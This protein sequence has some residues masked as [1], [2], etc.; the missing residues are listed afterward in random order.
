M[1]NNKNSGWGMLEAIRTHLNIPVLGKV[2]LV[3][4]AATD[5]NYQKATEILGTDLSG[6][7]RVF[8]GSDA[9]ASAYDQM[10]T[11]ANDVVLLEGQTAHTLT[12]MLT[13]SKSRC[14]FFGL[15]GGGRLAT[16]G[17]RVYMGVT[18]VATDLAPILNT[19]TRNTFRN[20]KVENASTTNES[21]YGFI[22]NGEGTLIEN[23]HFLKTAGLN[24]ANHAHFWLAGDS[25]TI[26]NVVVGQSN[27]PNT[28][29]GFGILIDGK[30]G[31]ASS[32]VKENFL[33][34]IYINMSVGGAVQATSCFIKIADTAAMNF[35]NVIKD[36]TCMNF[37]PVSGTIMTDA[38][39]APAS[40]VS[41][42]LFLRNPAFFG[43]TGVIDTASAG[44][45]IAA[46]GVAPV[47][48]GGLATNL[49]D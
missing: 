42:S 10:T 22:E 36:L 2:F 23:C 19:G 41:G 21:L 15:D 31:G 30:S 17:A 3:L 27:I 14:H 38:I 16:Q 37:I 33:E 29:A 20:M 45:Q 48:A 35:G 32:V 18:G 8:A 11:N 25:A 40:I 12:E 26:R 5:A 44:V 34:N 49:T 13:V 46:A 24:D 28:A 1:I 43:C 9:L 47:G 6:V 7:V 4:G 39:L